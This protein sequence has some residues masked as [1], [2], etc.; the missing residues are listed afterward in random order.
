MYDLLVKNGTIVDGTGAPS[1]R[2]DLAVRDGKIVAVGDASGPARETIDAEGCIVTPGF[3]DIHTHYDGQVSWD[4]VLAPSSINGVTS[5]A[6]GNCGVGFAP[7][8]ADKHDWLIQL[9]EGVEDIPGT[10]LAEGLTWDWES[11]PDYL[12]ALSQREYAIDLGAHLPHAALRAY[13]MGDRGGDHLERPSTGEIERM[14]RLTAEAMEAGALGFTTSRTHAHRSRDGL[15]IGTLTAEDPEL[16]GIVG[17]LRQ[18]GK[19]V[20]QLI[21]DAYLTADDA[22]ATA[23]LQLI[24]RLAET[25]GRRLSFTVQQTDDS[26]DRWKSIYREIDQMVADG[27]PVSAQVAP[28]PIGAILSFASTTNPFI[29]ARTYRRIA[30]ESASIDARL[31]ALADPA[32]RAAILEEHAAFHASEGF[33]AIITRGFTRMFR[34]TDPVDYEPHES[35]SLGAEAGRAGVDPAA[36]VYDTLMEEGGRRLLYMPLI[37]YAHGNLDDVHG[38]LT[39]NHVLYGLSDGGAHCGTICDGSF[40]TT[41]VA[42]W[43]R[44]NKAGLSTPLERLVHG[45]SQKNAA[46]VGWYDRGVLAP[47]YLADIN[48][49]SLDELALAPPEIVQDLPAGG[50]RLLQQ[51]RGYRAT[52]KSGVPTFSRGAWTGRTP[53]RLL[54]GAQ[55]FG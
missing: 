9:L 39:G 18:T 27:L 32:V 55:A 41:T 10:A 52:V 34:M 43:S 31:Q 30:A 8:R 54:R 49:I 46:H 20:I 45:Y 13:V 7:A 4:Q 35:Q 40:P 12:D 25:S 48:V 37:N 3:V 44:G 24:R 11:F 53:G 47:G 33:I 19:G 22:F 29:V 42:L 15:N 26:P 1:F 51:P 23:E 16:L 14:A 2:G 17:A 50:T 38:M 28:R 6:M 21:S 5:A 36:F